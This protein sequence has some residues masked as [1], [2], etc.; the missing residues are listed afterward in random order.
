VKNKTITTFEGKKIIISAFFPK[1]FFP[2]EAERKL[3]MK[4]IKNLITE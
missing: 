1:N 2:R 3:N 4:I